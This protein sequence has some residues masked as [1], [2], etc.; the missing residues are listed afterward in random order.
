MLLGFFSLGGLGAFDPF[1][2]LLA[3]SD[4]DAL[5]FVPLAFG[6]VFRAPDSAGTGKALP[7]LAAFPTTCTSSSGPKR[8]CSI[9]PVSSRSASSN[10][11]ASGPSPELG[12]VA[13][14]SRPVKPRNQDDVAS[15]KHPTR[16][17]VILRKVNCCSGAACR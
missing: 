1:F 12:C 9:S 14:G 4:L 8:A 2:A 11:P 5:L 7:P 13:D 16:S 10:L 15:E 3:P 17:S 6:V